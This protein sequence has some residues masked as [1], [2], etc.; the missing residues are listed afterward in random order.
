MADLLLAGRVALARNRKR[1]VSALNDV[2]Q[3]MLHHC[4]REE[5][6]VATGHQEV[7][8][9]DRQ[10]QAER[11]AADDCRHNRLLQAFQW[12]ADKNMEAMLSAVNAKK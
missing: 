10:L 11:T 1:R 8:G 7:L 6:K 2:A 5:E 9:E 12:T 3:Q 4:E